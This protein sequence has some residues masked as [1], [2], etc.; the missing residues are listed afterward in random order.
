MSATVGEISRNRDISARLDIRGEDELEDLAGSINAM[1]DSLE[2][3]EQSLKES[4]ER[5]RALFERAPDAILV[6]GLDGDEAGKI[7]AANQAAADQHGYTV[8]EIC[9]MK[10]FDLN[11]P[12]T[13]AVAPE[14]MQEIVRRRMGYPRG[15]ACQERWFPF[16]D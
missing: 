9:G 10:I 6:I 7:V 15:V 14:M 12:E 13:N 11:A 5:Y 4:E 1:L 8:E 16:P 2:S 3:A